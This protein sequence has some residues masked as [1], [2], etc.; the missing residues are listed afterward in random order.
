MNKIARKLVLSILTVVLTVIALG[1]TTFAW[2]T[3]TNTAQVQQFQAQIVADTGIEI[4]IGVPQPAEPNLGLNWVTTLTSAA[5]NQYISDAYGGAF[6]FQHVTSS[7]GRS[8]RTLGLDEFGEPITSQ[9]TTSGILVLPIHF[10]SASSNQILW[11]GASLSSTEADWLV[12]QTFTDETGTLVTAGSNIPIDASDSMRISVYGNLNTLPDPNVA[13]TYEKAAGGRNVLG[14]SGDL[15]GAETFVGSGVYVGANGAMNYYYSSTATL[16]G[17]IDTVSLVP[18]LTSMVSNPLVLD[19][20]SG[21][22]ATAGQEYYGTVNVRVWIE[23]WDANAYNSILDR[24]IN[25]SLVFE[26]FYTAP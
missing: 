24:I 18:T 15:R 26:G 3:L 17:G 5:V 22:S 6:R 4:A 20:S 19:M 12:N 10:R 14:Q 23:G 11:T 21:N 1:T 2:F 25:A 9:T 16:P 13:F 7:D 8:F